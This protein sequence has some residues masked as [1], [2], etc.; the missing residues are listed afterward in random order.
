MKGDRSYMP[1]VGDSVQ[2]KDEILRLFSEG[3]SVAQ[4]RQKFPTIAIGTL[5]T[6]KHAIDKTKTPVLKP[7]NLVSKPQAIGEAEA[8]AVSCEVVSENLDHDPSKK[9]LRLPSGSESDFSLVRKEM[10]A[11]LR[12]KSAKPYAKAIAGN[13]LLKAVEMRAT[14]PAS[15]LD[16]VQEST[17]H[18]ERK[19][20]TSKTADEL[21]Q[22]YRELL[23]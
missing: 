9:I 21:A 17:I 20:L 16:E 5:K 4:M 11:I 1:K 8:I 3:W 22:E 6:W 7:Q 23:S 12:D 13:L 2:H 15:V 18:Q 10:R 19:A 14:L